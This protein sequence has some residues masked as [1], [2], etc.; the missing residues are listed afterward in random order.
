MYEK[1]LEN[2]AVKIADNSSFSSSGN[3]YISSGILKF[4]MPGSAQH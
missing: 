4:I 3:S 2:D 1:L